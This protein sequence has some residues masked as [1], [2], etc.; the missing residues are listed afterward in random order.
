MRA[1]PEYPRS[2]QGGDCSLRVCG[3]GPGGQVSL[4]KA[5]RGAGPL[6]PEL[7]PPHTLG[8]EERRASQGP[9]PS[10]APH[11]PTWEV[12]APLP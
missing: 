5:G 12:R 3:R 7:G 9:C 6:A 11:P 8:P 10:L 2:G 1:H 4:L